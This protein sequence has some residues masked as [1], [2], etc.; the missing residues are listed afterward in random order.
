MA[1][2]YN[3]IVTDSGNLRDNESFVGMIENLGDAYEM[4]EE[5]YGMVWFLAHRLYPN[6]GPAQRDVV[7]T[8]RRNYQ[9]GLV[10]AQEANRGV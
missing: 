10:V 9:A 6:D 8:A 5:L 7:E 3:H 1:G 2:S 4:A